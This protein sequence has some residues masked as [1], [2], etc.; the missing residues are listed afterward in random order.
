MECKRDKNEE[1]WY[2]LNHMMIQSG[3][4]KVSFY[5]F[6]FIFT[7]VSLRKAFLKRRDRPTKVTM[8]FYQLKM[9]LY[10]LSGLIVI[11]D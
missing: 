8:W 7:L 2:M 11:N 1:H 5:P 9:F 6:F 10:F 3:F 4:I